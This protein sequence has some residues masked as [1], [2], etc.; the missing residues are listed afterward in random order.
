MNQQSDNKTES[1]VQLF[2]E[3]FQSGNLIEL[4]S[5]L[6][7]FGIDAV[8]SHVGVA[9]VVKDIPVVGLL[10]GLTK[11]VMDIR[12]YLLAKKVYNFFFG[13]RDIPLEKRIKFSND[14]CRENRED[15]AT[16]LLNILDRMNNQNNVPIICRLMKSKM[17]D[18][19]S[20]RDF[21]RCIL[22]LERISYTDLDSLLNFDKDYYEEG[23]AESFESAGLVY[24]SVIDPHNRYGGPQMRLSRTGR[25]LLKYGLEKPVSLEAPRTTRIKSDFG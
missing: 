2:E 3:T 15:T 8:L 4:T 9:E 25:I 17:N 5:S 11:T 1:T 24:L 10:V 16:A 18:N 19:I 22:A 21:N 7:E 13:I 23:V 12:T 6:G 20:M 14:Y